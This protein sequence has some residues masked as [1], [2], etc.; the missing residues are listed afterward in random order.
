[1]LAFATCPRMSF[2]SF[3]NSQTRVSSVEAVTEGRSPIPCRQPRHAPAPLR[4]GGAAGPAPSSSGGC[5]WHAPSAMLAWT[6]ALYLW[7]HSGTCL[8]GSPRPCSAPPSLQVHSSCLA[9]V[10]AQ[11]P[12]ACTQPVSPPGASVLLRASGWASRVVSRLETAFTQMQAHGLIQQLRGWP[13]CLA[14]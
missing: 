5:S 2:C 7:C 10:L 11:M 1:M 8:A 4:H 3:Y 12:H 9:L 13:P 14:S 6:S